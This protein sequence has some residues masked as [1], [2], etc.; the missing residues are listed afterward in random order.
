MDGQ[1][2][3]TKFEKW[4]DRFQSVGVQIAEGGKIPLFENEMLKSGVRFEENTPIFLRLFPLQQ[5]KISVLTMQISRLEGVKPSIGATEGV[6]W[7]DQW[8]TL[9]YIRGDE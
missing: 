5:L 1:S 8:N 4:T 6:R 2:G 9:G 3:W 7:G